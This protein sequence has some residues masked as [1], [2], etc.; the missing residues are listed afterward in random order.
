MAHVFADKDL[1]T[2]LLIDFD[3]QFKGE[4][5]P[6]SSQINIINRSVLFAVGKLPSDASL[7]H[8]TEQFYDC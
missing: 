4:Q 6:N 3:F 1:H 2:T 8:F 7:K 5:L